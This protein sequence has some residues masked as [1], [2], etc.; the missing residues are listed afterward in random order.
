MTKPRLNRNVQIVAKV[1]SLLLLYAASLAPAAG[2][3]QRYTAS[4][5]IQI[6]ASSL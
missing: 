5:S 2:S 6:K 4:V 1:V 3:V